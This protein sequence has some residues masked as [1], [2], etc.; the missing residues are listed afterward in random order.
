MHL[1]MSAEAGS[2]KLLQVLAR[3]CASRAR[4]LSVPAVTNACHLVSRT[5][6]RLDLDAPVPVAAVQSAP[7]DPYLHVLD[8]GVT[9][10]LMEVDPAYQDS[11]GFPFGMLLTA[12]WKPPLE[13]TDTVVAYPFFQDFV[14]SEGAASVQWVDTFLN[15]YVVE[16]PAVEQW[17]W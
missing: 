8:T 14:N 11:N 17:A 2:P 5:E 12:A 10:K 15:E 3:V 13:F 16:L 7:F 1:S 6:F 4:S 9:V